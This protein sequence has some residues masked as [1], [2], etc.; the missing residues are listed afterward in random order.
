MTIEGKKNQT[1]KNS[2]IPIITCCLATSATIPKKNLDALYKNL[3]K[4]VARGGWLA[5]SLTQSRRGARP[6]DT[7]TRGGSGYLSYEI[8]NENS[9][10]HYYKLKS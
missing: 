1:T 6:R 8:L 2:F 4:T 5:I 7:R 3:D 9:W 10:L